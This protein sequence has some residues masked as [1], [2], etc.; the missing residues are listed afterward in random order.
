M[1]ARDC[2]HTT[3]IPFFCKN[4]SLFKTHSTA[5]LS[6]FDVFPPRTF[7]VDKDALKRRYLDLQKTLHPDKL[8]CR[9]KKMGT[10]FSSWVGEGYRTL[11]DPGRRAAYLIG[12]ETKKHGEVSPEYM[13]KIFEWSSQAENAPP[14]KNKETVSEIGREMQRKEKELSLLFKR[15]FPPIE[16]VRK[17][18]HEYRYCAEVKER[19]QKSVSKESFL[20]RERGVSE[21]R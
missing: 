9:Q 21:V 3:H 6:Y 15:A 11:L 8:P 13:E 4:C 10:L 19:V 1:E 7:D 18:I 14:E 2:G 16:E 17:R 20:E 5:A 12:A